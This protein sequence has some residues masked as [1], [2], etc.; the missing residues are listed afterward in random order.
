MS[1]SL[2]ERGIPENGTPRAS[3]RVA[4]RIGAHR[5]ALLALAYGSLAAL[6]AVPMLITSVPLGVDVLSHLARIHVLAHIGDDPNLAS[7]YEVRHNLRP[8]L[9]MDVLVTPL[10]HVLP[11]LVVGRVL[12]VA[13]VWGLVGTVAVLRFAFLRRVG[14]APA[15]AGLFA[16]NGLIAWGFLNYELGLI[17]ALLGFAAWHAARN[18]PW[19]GRLA[20]FASIS[21]AIYLT[22]ILA[23]GLYGLLVLSYE[24]FGQS[25]PWR[26]GWRD[27]VVL[28][29]Q[30][31]PALV[32]W[33]G[34]TAAAPTAGPVLSYVPEGKILA[35][36]SPLLY[37][38][39]AGGPDA[40]LTAFILIVTT[41]LFAV[42][43]GW[44]SCPRALAAP[45]LASA[46][47]ALVIPT[48][49]A[50]VFLVDARLPLAAVCLAAAGLDIRTGRS[51][52]K[53]GV[54][55]V[56]ACL[57]AW[58]VLDVS[59]LTAACDAQYAELR[60][61]LAVLPRGAELI[62]TLDPADGTQSR[63]CTNLPIFL[64]AAQLVAIDRSGYAPDFFGALTSVGPRGGRA[65][66]QDPLPTNRLSPVPAGV[67]VL[68]L[69][70]G[71]SDP[72]PP[73]LQPVYS[74]S[75]FDILEAP[76]AESAPL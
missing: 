41:V 62:T 45:A 33:V 54:A 28:T 1:D 17:F 25:R 15:A 38:G 68:R 40:G 30:A 66:D 73:G 71:E 46:A 3:D 44:L 60:R 26:R 42:R 49:L 10:A 64:H 50:H 6:L 19:A 56:A 5:R 72:V 35:V 12:V 70:L 20:G 9:G 58:H 13:L 74:G 76:D 27:L 14:L 52:V 48:W 57:T 21:T 24:A 32:L 31:V 29:G 37:R 34:L 4:L 8:Y 39:A 18:L 23:F 67:R 53:A 7:L 43:S 16:Y 61:G 51:G 36:A 55:L 22:H 69:R 11:T 59:E 65:S 2:I 63:A 75:F 47:A